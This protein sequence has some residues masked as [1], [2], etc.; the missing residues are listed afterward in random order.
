MTAVD[1][2]VEVSFF[3]AYLRVS[4][5]GFG[6]RGRGLLA[7]TLGAELLLCTAP[8]FPVGEPEL[9]NLGVRCRVLGK[10]KFPLLISVGGIGV[11]KAMG[12]GGL[13]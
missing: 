6:S 12:L 8:C 9:G 4:R 3:R 5:M 10:A 13:D 2:G 11:A 1:G 7:G